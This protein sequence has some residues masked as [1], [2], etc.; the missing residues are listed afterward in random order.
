MSCLCA[1]Y[2]SDEAR[3]SRNIDKEIF[4][5]GHYFMRQV[6]VLLLGA[7]ETGK[8]TFAKQMR[9]IYGED[10]DERDLF[11]FRT[12]IYTNVL[13]AMQV[14]VDAR[15]KLGIA[16]GNK[17]N[18]SRA[19]M[20][21][22]WKIPRSVEQSVFL[23]NADLL[24]HLWKDKG[25]QAAFGRRR[26]YQ[27]PDSTKYFME[28]LPIL[29]LEDYIPTIEDALRSRKVTRGI[30]EYRTEVAR[31]PFLFVDVGG[32]RHYRQKWVLCFENVTTV[33]FFVATSEYDEVLAEDRE[34]NRLQES[35][36]LF[37]DIVNSVTFVST[38]VIIFFNKM[39]QLREKI[40]NCDIAN[41]FPAFKGNSRN[42]TDVKRF[43][44]TMF[45]STRMDNSK[46]LFHHF[47]TAIDTSNIRFVFDAVKQII[48]QS[49]L[50]NHILL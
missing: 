5:D 39:D 29:R 11:E 47:T 24:H 14:L 31:V 7:G 20:L 48:L 38:H 9:I 30:V 6:K 50:E 4:R 43:L 16:W 3:H 1:S 26:E 27:L 49:S 22:R 42:E 13:K 35:L 21:L 33:L 46:T 19:E 37:S 36:D 2:Y 10:Y 40:Q 15:R 45:E 44:Y 32:Q 28:R 12:L 25:I 41:Y 34:T 8:S 23:A 18:D 17:R